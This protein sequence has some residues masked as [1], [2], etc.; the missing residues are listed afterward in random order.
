MRILG[1]ANGSANFTIVT[2]QT[3]PQGSANA[4]AEDRVSGEGGLNLL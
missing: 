4:N 3:L 2:D 1:F